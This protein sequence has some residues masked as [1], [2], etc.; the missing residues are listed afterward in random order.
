MKKIAKLVLYIFATF[1]VTF[2]IPFSALSDFI[3]EHSVW[4]N[5]GDG[6]DAYDNIDMIALSLQIAVS[7]FIVCIAVR[8]IKFI[9]IEFKK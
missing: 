6:E 1:A 7:A 5:I 2:I 8:I 9:L 4:M 3:A